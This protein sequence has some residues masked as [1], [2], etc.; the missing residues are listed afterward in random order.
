MGLRRYI[1]DIILPLS[2]LL[3]GSLIT[4]FFTQLQSRKEEQRKYKEH[5]YAQ[6]LRLLQGF[7][8]NTATDETKKAFFDEY[9]Q[10]WVYA[11]DDVIITTKK[12]IDCM[13]IDAS[14]EE[15]RNGKTLLGNIVKAIRR[16]MGVISK[17]LAEPFEYI[18]VI[19]ITHQEDN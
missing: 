4:Y 9:Y 17:I 12:L 19:P 7:V 10:S 16:D 6:L 2:T 8:G 1:V 14:A 18:S 11:S 5:K 13:K 3:F 15:R